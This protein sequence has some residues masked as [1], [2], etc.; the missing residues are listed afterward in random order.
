LRLFAEIEIASEVKP[1]KSILKFFRRQLKDP[2]LLRHFKPNGVIVDLL[3]PRP[4][5]DQNGRNVF[6][7]LAQPR[8]CKPCKTAGGAWYRAKS[9]VCSGTHEVAVQLVSICRLSTKIN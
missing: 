2:D 3:G 9:V 1:E 8:A 4:Y 6:T 7:N 5:L